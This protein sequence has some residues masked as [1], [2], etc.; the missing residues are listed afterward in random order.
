MTLYKKHIV[1]FLW[2]LLGLV[3]GWKMKKDL[4]SKYKIK[5]VNVHRDYEVKS[6]NLTALEANV[7][8]MD[9]FA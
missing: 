7:F 9:F 8:Y 2:I 4:I 3:F 5:S 1:I 6:H